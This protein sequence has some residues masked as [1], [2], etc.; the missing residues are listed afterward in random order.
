MH[1]VIADHALFDRSIQ[2]KIDRRLGLR[3]LVQIL[4]I[5]AY[6]YQ[7]EPEN[8]VKADVFL[9]I[10]KFT[11]PADRLSWYLCTCRPDHGPEVILADAL[12]K[13]LG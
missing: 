11:L 12:S 10:V 6:A 7:A 5:S 4:I 1:G 9:Y 13:S 2:V 3:R 8:S